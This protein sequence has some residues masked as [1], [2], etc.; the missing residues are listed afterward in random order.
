M[1]KFSQFSNFAITIDWF[2]HSPI[3][4]YT[5]VKSFL[6]YFIFMGYLLRVIFLN[7]LFPDCK[8]SFFSVYT[9]YS[10]CTCLIRSSLTIIDSFATNNFCNYTKSS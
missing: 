10:C 9:N 8:N 4:L 5:F 2:Y 7:Q 3:V 1:S 6:R